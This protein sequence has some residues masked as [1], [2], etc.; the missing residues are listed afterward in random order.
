MG[1]YINGNQNDFYWQ[2]PNQN[3]GMS[4]NFYEQDYSQFANQQLGELSL[5]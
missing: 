2:Q 4:Q 3:P 1:D 5:I